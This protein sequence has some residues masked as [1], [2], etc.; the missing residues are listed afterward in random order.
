MGDDSS[1]VNGLTSRYLR[2]V[3]VSYPEKSAADR[4]GSASS[5]VAPPP[6]G[7]QPGAR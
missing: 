4:L 5:F 3:V 1:S 7:G 6:S 2:Q